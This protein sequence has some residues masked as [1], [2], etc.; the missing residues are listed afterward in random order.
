MKYVGLSDAEL[1][2]PKDSEFLLGAVAKIW[3]VHLV[4]IQSVLPVSV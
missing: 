3:S 1:I 4:D 2:R